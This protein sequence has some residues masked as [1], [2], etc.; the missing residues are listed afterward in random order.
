MSSSPFDFDVVTGPPEPRDEPK[1]PPRPV[2]GGQE[3]QAGA[4]PAEPMPAK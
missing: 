3:P 2:S 1:A 4:P